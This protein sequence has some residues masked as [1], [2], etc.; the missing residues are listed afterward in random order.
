MAIFILLADSLIPCVDPGGGG[1]GGHLGVKRGDL[2]WK[3]AP[4]VGNYTFN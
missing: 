4:G 2:Q 3:L 1:G